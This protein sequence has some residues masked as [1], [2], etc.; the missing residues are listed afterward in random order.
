[1]TMDSLMSTDGNI[2][3]NTR[4]VFPKLRAAIR[5]ID[6]AWESCSSFRS[7]RANPKDALFVASFFRQYDVE[8]AN[9]AQAACE[10]VITEAAGLI[11]FAAGRLTYQAIRPRLAAVLVLTREPRFFAPLIQMIARSK[12]PPIS[13]EKRR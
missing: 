3:H 12:V 4:A 1:M 2:I 13:E 11:G 9:A 6:D 8:K 7:P 10:R 5:L